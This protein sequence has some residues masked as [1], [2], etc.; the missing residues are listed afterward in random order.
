VV[1]WGFSVTEVHSE[2]VGLRGA[3]TPL[4][5]EDSAHH[6]YRSVTPRRLA[7][8]LTSGKGRQVPR[9]E[10]RLR[11]VTER[12]ASSDQPDGKAAR[13]VPVVDP[14]TLYLMQ[15]ADSSR[16]GVRH[17]L[18]TVAGL[19]EPGSDA[20]SF[21]WSSVTFADVTM[22]KAALGQRYKWTVA[23][24]HLANLKGLLRTVWQMAC[25]SSDQYSRGAA[26]QSFRGQAI[27][28]GRHI[29]DEEWHALFA[30]VAADTSP[31][32]RRDLA[33]FALAR[34]TGARRSSL[35]GINVEDVNLTDLEVRILGKGRREYIAAFGAWCRGPLTAWLKVRGSEDGPLFVRMN[36]N[37]KP[38]VN[39]RLSSSGMQEVLER[40]IRDHNL[41]PWTWHDAR[42]SM[43]TSILDADGHDLEAAM[44]QA[45]HSN[46]RTTLRYSRRESRKL[47]STARAIPSPF[48]ARENT[49]FD[50]EYDRGLTGK[51]RPWVPDESD[52][53]E[54]ES[55]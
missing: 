20:S 5:R 32:G 10:A 30:A 11:A 26:V 17:R 42:R 43:V 48:E 2:L 1:Q 34:A 6:A 39:N 41:E 12:T 22:V 40:R 46:P 14:I 23:N 35:V 18:D 19:L 7:G 55:E 28:T 27:P 45:N 37:G 44:V 8:H 33:L 25:M 24:I 4:S 38:L 50:A 54:E 52:V 53:E 36:R 31:R 49:K 29:S 51:P 13:V 3:E 15:Q 16:S 47:R 9:S 21:D